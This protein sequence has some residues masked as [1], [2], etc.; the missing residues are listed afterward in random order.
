MV[1]KPTGM[2]IQVIPLLPNAKNATVLCLWNQ[3]NAQEPNGISKMFEANLLTS[4]AHSPPC[5]SNRMPGWN[6]QERK[7]KPARCQAQE[8]DWLLSARE[9]CSAI[10]ELQLL[11]S[12]KMS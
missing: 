11:S 5:C 8:H 10:F 9:S 1:S 7:P 2:T 12:T 3:S 4:C 6:H